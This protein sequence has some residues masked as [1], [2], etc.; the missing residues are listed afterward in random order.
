MICNPFID[1]DHRTGIVAIRDA[2]GIAQR[3]QRVFGGIVWPMGSETSGYVLVA[4]EH[5][6]IEVPFITVLAEKSCPTESKLLFG[7]IQL[8]DTFCCTL[9]AAD[10]ANE[11]AFRKFQTAD[12]LVRYV[13]HRREAIEERFPSYR[14]GYMKAVV[15]KIPIG[16]DPVA[17]VKDMIS[18][19]VNGAPRLR[20][21]SCPLLQEALRGTVPSNTA[22]LHPAVKALAYCL[23]GFEMM[24]Y[25]RVGQKVGITNWVNRR[26]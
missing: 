13:D 18:Q 8:K 26:R 3:F 19:H 21:G 17:K 12:G 24:P 11:L 25:V 15:H 7:T 10:P 22:E 9:F 14:A 6:D 20:V 23:S 2:Q 16:L 1:F 4:G 5:A